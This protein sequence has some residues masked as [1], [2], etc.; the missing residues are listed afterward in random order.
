MAK[1]IYTVNETVTNAYMMMHQLRSKWN[2]TNFGMC[3]I[4][5]FI[6]KELRKPPKLCK[7]SNTM[8]QQ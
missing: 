3:K 2:A 1:N 5:C 7:G 8:H 6:Q 4:E